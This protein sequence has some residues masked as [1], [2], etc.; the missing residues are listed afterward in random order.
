MNYKCQKFALYVDFS[1]VCSCLSSIS[2]LAGLFTD[3]N[4]VTDII[5]KIIFPLSFWVGLGF[6]EFFIWK[7]DS[8]RKEIEYYEDYRK[9]RGKP[10]VLSISK[11]KSGAI[12]D[13]LL[14]ASLLFF[15]LFIFTGFGEKVI[16]NILIFLLV[17][18]F[19]LHCILNGKNFRY[20]KYLEKRKVDRSV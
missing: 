16:Q 18:S 19:R 12:A 13:L 9:I 17:L 8:L 4:Q 7:A 15:V 6:E 3:L 11:T 14:L 20:K 10:G 1:I 2:L 5:I